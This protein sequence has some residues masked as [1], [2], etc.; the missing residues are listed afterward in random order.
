MQI[1]DT[2]AIV[3]G[4]ASGLGATSTA[5][6]EKCATVFVF[7][8]PAA[9]EKATAVDCIT[10]LAVDLTNPEQVKA[11][12]EEAALSGIPLRTVVNSAGIGPVGPHPGQRRGTRPRPLRHGDHD[13]PDRYVQ[14]A[15]PCVRGDREG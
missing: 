5:M 15:R 8:L 10:Y 7:D 9:I 14:R 12:A 11:G 6:V 2:A 4:G 13:W 3:T 1:S